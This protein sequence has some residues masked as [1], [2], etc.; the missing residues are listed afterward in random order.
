MTHE[1]YEGAGYDE[2]GEVISEGNILGAVA[3]RPQRHPQ[4]HPQQQSARIYERPPLPHVPAHPHVSRLRSFMGVG[5]AKW[6]PTD[7]GDIPLPVQPQESFRIGRMIVDV[8]S[9]STSTGNASNGIVLV[10]RLDVGTQPQSPSVEQPAPAAMFA[11]N[12]T[13]SAIDTQIAYR[14]TTIQVTLGISEAPGTDVTVT[15]VVG[16]FGDWIR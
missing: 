9:V 4:Q 10:R 15:A 5:I 2:A 8:N 13:Y 11:A 14:A 12:A 1:E 6:Q 7:A 3:R 16:F